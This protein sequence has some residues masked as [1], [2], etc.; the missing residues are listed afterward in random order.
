MHLVV[1]GC[2]DSWHTHQIEQAAAEAGHRLWSVDWSRLAARVNRGGQP[3]VADAVELTAA[4]AILARAMPPGS[5][6][7]V[8]FRMDALARVQA[9]EEEGV[10][11]H[12]GADDL[13]RLVHRGE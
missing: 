9:E 13:S 7:Q 11:R 5:L 4:D 6:E 1:L 10:S 12:P 2:P 3:V 8:I